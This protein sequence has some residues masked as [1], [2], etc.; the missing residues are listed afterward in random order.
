MLIL[1]LESTCDET[2][3]AVVRDG[4]TI[5]S[6]VVFSQADMH[7]VYGGVIPELASRRHLEA[8]IPVI[9]Q[10][11]SD[12]GVTLQEIDKI[13]VANAPGLIGALL[14]GLNAAKSLAF[15]LQKPIV[16]INHIEAHLYAAMMDHQDLSFPLLG[17]IISGGHTSLLKVEGIGRYTMIGQTSDDA[18]G[19]A[20]DKVA[21]MLELPYPGGP[22]IEKLAKMGNPKAYPF[23]GGQ[24][25]GRE[26]DFSF[27]GLKTAVLYALRGQNEKGQT[28]LSD[29]QKADLA[30]SFQH[31]AFTDLLDK[32]QKALTRFECQGL[33]FG[34][35][36]SNSQTLR[37]L[38][39]ER[40][41]GVPL[42]WP[43]PQLSLDNAAM[44]AAL[45]FHKEFDDLFALKAETRS[46]F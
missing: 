38:V 46:F 34:G 16:G 25:K 7:A 24:V 30:A 31:A 18:V 19:E 1:G 44:I 8:I 39:A 20:F 9:E 6:N 26:F 17:L 42:Y 40:F 22:E 12:A 29:L 3:A 10:A 11:C 36:V 43:A 23:K 35:G 14:I 21:K 5:L 2:A 33:V 41:S 45:A 37:K 15:A 13:A 28:P 4:K 32:C 27:S